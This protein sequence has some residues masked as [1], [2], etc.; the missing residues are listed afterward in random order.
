MRIGVENLDTTNKDKS[1]K[2][3]DSDD[4][5]DRRDDSE[6][7]SVRRNESRNKRRLG[8]GLEGSPG[9]DDSESRRGFSADESDEK[10]GG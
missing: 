7:D 6:D 2:F 1:R 3:G 8:A 4:D 5:D 10:E 9:S